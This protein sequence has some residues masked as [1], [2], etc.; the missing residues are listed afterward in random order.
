MSKQVPPN[1]LTD[2]EIVELEKQKVQLAKERQKRLD[3][4][5]FAGNVKTAVSVGVKLAAGAYSL[6][7]LDQQW[8]IHQGK[9]AAMVPPPAAREPGIGTMIQ[10]NAPQ[11][12]TD[13]IATVGNTVQVTGNALQTIGKYGGKRA[14]VGLAVGTTL[15]AASYVPGVTQSL[16]RTGTQR[17]GEMGARTL[18]TGIAGTGV[19]IARG[20]YGAFWDIV[21][22]IEKK[23]TE[24]SW[25]TYEVVKSKWPS[26]LKLPTREEAEVMFRT[27]RT[28]TPAN[29][30]PD[31]RPI[32]SQ[33]IYQAI[34]VMT[35]QTPISRLFDK[36]IKN[37]NK[38]D[39]EVYNSLDQDSKDLLFGRV[40]KLFT[41]PEFPSLGRFDATKWSMRDFKLFRK[42]S[43]DMKTKIRKEVY[44]GGVIAIKEALGIKLTVLD[45]LL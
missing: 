38:R 34:N 24:M 40:V 14:A 36:S 5:R 42:L 29:Y 18:I 22:Q 33:L 6:Y 39:W 23:S 32:S 41:A 21:D 20:T 28:Q 12:V 9:M 1:K 30:I 43:E 15:A 17:A 13:V 26:G 27:P 16:V 3:Q 35:G 37:W 4:E 10:E 2:E 19:G 11:A 31:T 25:D 8:R 45:V 7:A 44:T